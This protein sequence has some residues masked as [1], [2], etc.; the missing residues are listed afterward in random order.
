MTKEGGSSLSPVA[1]RK[2]PMHTRCPV[3]V[4]GCTTLGHL[5]VNMGCQSMFFSNILISNPV[6]LGNCVDWGN[7]SVR[8][9]ARYNLGLHHILSRLVA[10]KEITADDQHLLNMSAIAVDCAAHIK[11]I[12]GFTVPCDPKP[13]WLL[14]LFLDQLGL[15]L[16]Y[17]K[18]GT[19]GQQVKLFSLSK[20]E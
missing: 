9:L 12:L 20:K 11:A 3:A 7:Y 2:A 17:R 1:T 16:T 4:K 14:G 5:P 8:W 13:I 19:R 10:G 15:K 6:L 18:Q